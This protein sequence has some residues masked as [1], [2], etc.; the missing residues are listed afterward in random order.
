MIYT[1]LSKVKRLITFGKYHS[2]EKKFIKFNRLEWKDNSSSDSSSGN[3]LVYV[4]NNY[5]R[6]IV[7]TLL[8]AKKMEQKLNKKIIVLLES[9]KSDS[10]G[11]YA[12]YESFNIKKYLYLKSYNLGSVFVSLYESLILYFKVKTPKDLIDLKYN[13]INIGEEIYDTILRLNVEIYTINSIQ[14]SYFKYI[15]QAVYYMKFYD[16]LLMQNSI[17][18]II[19]SDLDYV[20]WC[21][22]GK[23][24]IKH[25]CILFQTDCGRYK[26]YENVYGYKLEHKIKVTKAEVNRALME[27]NIEKKIENYL[28][29]RFS[30]VAINQFDKS[31]FL[32]KRIYNKQEL[33]RKCGIFNFNKKVVFVAAHVFSDVAHYG[34]NTLYQDYYHWLIETIRILNTNVDI[35]VF[36]KSH[37]S[38]KYYGEID[39]VKNII[40]KENLKNIFY[41]P[42]D[43]NTIGVKDIA[44]YIVTCQG[45][46]GL[47]MACF[48]IPVLT[49]SQGYY[50]GF[51]IDIN[52][53]S[54]DEYEKNLKEIT[55]IKRLPKEKRK[56][57]KLILYLTFSKDRIKVRPSLYPE[58]CF[59]N[60]NGWEYWELP[61]ISQYEVI[62]ENFSKGKKIKDEYYD[63][64]LE[65]IV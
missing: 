65:L 63:N 56:I 36:V 38:S 30:G 2:E 13:G 21:T 5:P 27:E 49:A 20:P 18:T 4:K 37:P 10:Y 57:A 33:F 9:N 14:F 7:E 1:L 48:G 32:G 8:F 52:A 42:D 55:S 62:N 40:K 45:T 64:V 11:K 29:Q 35:N 41:V 24:G 6:H 15:F 47:E 25:K 59:Y 3:I 23:M 17:D 60:G 61:N 12:I 53:R 28:E 51:G 44:D 46:M 39:I 26:K 58:D 34:F 16:R 54:K 31:A 50:S 22:L 43:F 19:F